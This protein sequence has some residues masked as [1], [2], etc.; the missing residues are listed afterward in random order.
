MR[1]SIPAVAPQDLLA[2]LQAAGITDE[3]I[4]EVVVAGEAARD[5]VTDFDAAMRAGLDAF[6]AR[7]RRL[8]ELVCDPAECSPPWTFRED[9]NLSKTITPDG[10][11]TVLLV[12]G[13]RATAT[14]DHAQPARVRGEATIASVN[15]GQ[16]L[17]LPA[18][19]L[20]AAP[21]AVEQRPEYTWLLMVYRPK[22]ASFAQ[23]ELSLPTRVDDGGRVSG[24]HLRHKLP[25]VDLTPFVEVDQETETDGVEI[26]V[27]VTRKS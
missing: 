27:P 16:Q 8:R 20:E 18:V 22:G 15:N 2:A 14:T 10:S 23:V 6:F 24:W 21:R 5:D 3:V 19:S 9:K 1:H 13:D 26:D 17:T 4:R 25:A 11:H 7:V 12:T